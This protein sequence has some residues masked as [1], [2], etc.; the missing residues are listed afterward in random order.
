MELSIVIS[1]FVLAVELNKRNDE[2]LTPSR[3]ILSHSWIVAVKFSS[4]HGMGFAGV[5]K[6]A[7]LPV[8]DIPLASLNFDLGI[9][10]GRFCLCL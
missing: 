5:L 3:W 2:S 6:G 1:I 10:V 8:N 4:L 7:G 9:E